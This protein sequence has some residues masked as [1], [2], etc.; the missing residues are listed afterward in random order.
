MNSYRTR[1]LT[2]G[3]KSLIFVFFI[4]LVGCENS[5][6]LIKNEWPHEF[7]FGEKGLLYE[8]FL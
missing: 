5:S 3:F 7:L 6:E 2:T 4:G 1:F 8:I